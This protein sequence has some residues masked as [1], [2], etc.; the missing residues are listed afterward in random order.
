MRHRVTFRHPALPTD[1]EP[2]ATFTDYGSASAEILATGGSE[3]LRG[4]QVD[5]T[6]TTIVRTRFQPILAAQINGQWQITHG[7][8]TLAVVAAYDPTGRREILE[9]QCREAT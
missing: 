4:K 1:G 7:D 2:D 8:T 6:V 3:R 5:S 9:I